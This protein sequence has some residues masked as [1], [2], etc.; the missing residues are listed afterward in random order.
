MLFYR[1]NRSITVQCAFNTVGLVI[2]FRHTHS[3]SRSIK[4]GLD[5]FV[6]ILSLRGQNFSERSNNYQFSYSCF[7]CSK[8]FTDLSPLQGHV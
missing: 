5:L 4:I 6:N 7:H 3:I 8:F 1:V 2:I